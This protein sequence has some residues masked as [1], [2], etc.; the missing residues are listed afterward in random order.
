MIEIWLVRHGQTV[1]NF[2]RVVQGQL[3]GRLSPE[4]ILQAQK[5]AEALKDIRFDIIYS[6]DLGRARETTSYIQENHPRAQVFTSP[7]LR[8]KH[9]GSLQGKKVESL[10]LSFSDP[11]R[12]IFTVMEGETP[13][14]VGQR[15]RS[16][17][18]KLVA[19]HQGQKVLLVGHGFLNSCFIN[20]LLNEEICYANL[21]KQENTAV[22]YFLLD[23]GGR[24]VHGRLNSTEHL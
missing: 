8:E 12:S 23:E 15:A 1:E 3:D 21:H 6:S 14:E 17:L 19:E 9:F 13:E 10:G 18:E 22:N 2:T 4:G 24:L 11:W 16:L 5:V 20:L 7:L